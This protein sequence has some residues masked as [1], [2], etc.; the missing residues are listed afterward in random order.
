MIMEGIIGS[1]VIFVSV[2][3]IVWGYHECKS[4]KFLIYER[5]AVPRSH[6]VCEQKILNPD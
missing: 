4:N 2:V 6:V 5:I 1:V 3:G